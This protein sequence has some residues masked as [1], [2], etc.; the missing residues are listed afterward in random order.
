MDVQGILMLVGLGFGAYFVTRTALRVDDR[1]EDKKRLA[2][3]LATWTAANGLPT[4]SQILSDF[5]I[6]D[7]SGVVSGIKNL[8]AIVSNP[9]SARD[10]LN[11][12]LRVQLDKKLATAE[13]RQ[14]LVRYVEDKLNVK[15]SAAALNQPPTALEPTNASST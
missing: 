5:A 9:E 11:S 14:E 6:N 4:L 15:I 12:F 7:L 8:N 3:N 1:V 13:G 2:L 10:S